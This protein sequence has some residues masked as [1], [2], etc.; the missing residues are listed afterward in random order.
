MEYLHTKC[1]ASTPK[2]KLLLKNGP[3]QLKQRLVLFRGAFGGGGGGGRGVSWET[4]WSAWGPLRALWCHFKRK[5]KTGDFFIHMSNLWIYV[6]SR[7]RPD[8]R[9]SCVA[10]TLTLD[11]TRILSTFFF[12]RTCHSY[13]H[14]WLLP[15]YAIFIDL[16]L[17][18]RKGVGVGSQGQ[19][20]RLKFDEMLKHF[21]LTLLILLFS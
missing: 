3:L 12:F 20:I 7:D 9:P 5:L 10:K 1:H 13:R 16:D 18:W 14:H 4:E 8:G 17:A 6:M 2:C 21:K 15:F 19:L 11:I